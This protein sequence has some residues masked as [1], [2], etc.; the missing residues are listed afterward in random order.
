M[1]KFEIKDGTAIIPEGVKVI[2]D[3]AFQGCTSLK[4]I[5]IPESVTKIGERAFSG[6]TSLESIIIS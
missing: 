2:E 6:C 5:T 1:A 3:K 4:S